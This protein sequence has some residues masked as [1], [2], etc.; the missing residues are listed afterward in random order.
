MS[1]LSLL[2][3]HADDHQ[4]VL[5]RVAD[6][7]L[8]R[9]GE[10]GKAPGYLWDEGGEPNDLHAQR[11]GILAPEGRRGDRL[12]E[13]VAPL[14]AHRREQ[15]GGEPVR[16]YRVPEK[17]SAG[18]AAQWKKTVFRP[19]RELDVE[20]PRYQLILGDLHEVPLS[21]QQVQG[22]DGYVGRLAFDSDDDYAAYVAKVLRWERSPAPEVQ[23]RALFHTVHDGSSATEIGYHA[24]VRPGVSMLRERMDRGQVN[25]DQVVESGDADPD[26]QG[27]LNAAR[28]DR[29]AFLFS[30]SHG[31][32]PPRRGWRSA[33]DQR[34]GQGAMSFGRG[35]RIRGED[36]RDAVFLPGGV[37]FML[38]CFGAGSPSESAYQHWLEE[39]GALGHQQ[40]RP[41]AALAGI[42]KERPFVAAVPRAVLASP[43]G[44]LGF[45]GHVDLAWTYSFRELDQRAASRPAKFMGVLRSALKRDRLGIGLR[46]LSRY[47]GQANQELT[48]LADEERARGIVAD[49]ARR[50]QKAHLWMLRQDLAAYVLL[51]DPAA[52]L[53]L[54]EP[55]GAT[56]RRPGD[57]RGAE[58][59][60]RTPSIAAMNP[61][62]TS[63]PSEARSPSAA[64]PE[65]A[66]LP[67]AIDPLERAIG[68]VLAGESLRQVALEHGVESDALRSAAKRYRAGGRRALGVPE[69]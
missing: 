66:P 63:S 43:N 45:I 50:A 24:L 49:A 30:L 17:M 27:L 34:L 51:G 28:I 64:T 31:E 52:R 61:R 47:L 35:G 15:Q 62:R 25:A 16:V 21:L 59:H 42:P 67:L 3:V 7:A 55:G 5:D 57:A 38:A 11:W 13:I 1:D 60:S 56:G 53:P 68:R 8:A 69:G 36:L 37:W 40:A 18:E 9:A 26:P 4:P 33:D 58:L 2:M 29:P 39:L 65:P 14:V 54:A 12:L 32:G 6:G 23:G 20:V 41:Q 46:E 10:G 22:S 19:Q 44:P 48:D